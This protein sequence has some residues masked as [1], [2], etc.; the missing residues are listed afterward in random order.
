MGGVGTGEFSH[1]SRM[2]HGCCGIHTMCLGLQKVLFQTHTHTER[3]NRRYIIPIC[4][5]YCCL[6]VFS[7]PLCHSTCLIAALVFSPVYFD[8]I[9]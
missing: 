5:I 4:L 1:T 7:A 3:E 2:K 6:H 9:L 8:V